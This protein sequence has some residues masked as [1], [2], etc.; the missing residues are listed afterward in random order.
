MR[1]HPGDMRS[2]SSPDPAPHLRRRTFM[3]LAKFEHVIMRFV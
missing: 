1:P 3:A 2:N